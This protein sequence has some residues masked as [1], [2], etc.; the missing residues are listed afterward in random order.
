MNRSEY[1]LWVQ[2]VAEML[3]RLDALS[4]A[5]EEGIPCRD[6]RFAVETS[7]IRALDVLGLRLLRDLLAEESLGRIWHVHEEDECTSIRSS[8][9]RL[10]AN[11]STFRFVCQRYAVGP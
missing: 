10:Q 4:S 2:L 8:V 3:R 7:E 6:P 1:D 9:V 11:R 5:M